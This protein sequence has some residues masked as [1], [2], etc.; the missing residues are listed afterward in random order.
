MRILIIAAAV[1]A[2]AVVGYKYIDNVSI[3]PNKFDSV[4][5]PVDVLSPE[6]AKAA[7][8]AKLKHEHGLIGIA[9]ETLE[10]VLNEKAVGKA[11]TDSE[12][13]ARIEFTPPETGDY[14]FTV[15]LAPDSKRVAPPAPLNLCVRKKDQQFFVTDIDGTISDAGNFEFLTKKPEDIQPMKDSPEALQALSKRYTIIYLTG[16]E[17]MFRHKTKAWLADKGFPVGPV[18]FWDIQKDEFSAGK[19]KTELLEK[20]RKDWPNIVAGAGDQ[21][22]DAAAYQANGVKA[23]I[24]RKPNAES[25]EDEKEERAEFPQGAVFFTSWKDLQKMLLPEE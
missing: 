7:L 17:E 24:F 23:Y 15:R 4:I 12:G 22:S 1:C 10:F 16:R 19:Y 21:V 25:A 13:V 8:E 3:N 6:G 11:Q 2:L 18:Y 20:L 14:V 5:I 9:G